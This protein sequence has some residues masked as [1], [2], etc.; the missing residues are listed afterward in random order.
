MKGTRITGLVFLGLMIITG[1]KK[2]EYIIAT[3]DDVLMGAYFERESERFSSFHEMLVKSGTL[4]FLNAYG[5]YTCFAPTNEAI[6]DF[7]V[8]RGKSSLDDFTTAE[9]VDLVRYHV[10]IDTLNSTR[11]T[12]GK[13]ST[14]NMYGQYLT[15]STYYESGQ[16]KVKINKYAEVE[17]LDIRVANGIIHSLK[18]VLEPIVVPIAGLV[19]ADPGLTIFT[20]ALKATGFYDTLSLVPD[21]QLERADKRWF[22]LFVHT[23]SVYSAEGINSFEDLKARYSDTGNPK[24][25]KD[26]LN[27]YVAYHILDNSLKYVADLVQENAHLTMAPLEVITIRLKQDSVLI[28]EDEFRGQIEKGA[29]V[30]R[31]KSDNTAANGVFHYVDANFAIKVRLPYA[32]YWDVCDQPEIRKLPGVF[33]VPGASAYLELGQLAGITWSTDVPIQYVCEAGGVQGQYLVHSDMMII[34]L[35]TASINWIEFKTPLIVKGKY[36]LWICTR[37]VDDPNRRPIFLVYFNGEAL[38]NIVA[39][40][41]TMERVSDEELLFQGFK[42]YNYD[43]ADSTGYLTDIN[44][45]FASRLAGTI[46]VPTTGNHTIKFQVINNG[47]KY[48]WIDMIHIIPFEN[49]QIWP[50]VGHDGTLMDKPDWY[51]LPQE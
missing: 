15:A 2:E 33:R 10:I 30:N 28:N 16:A 51:P 9:L 29:P 22:T 8:S 42:R 38:P 7:L 20:E 35:R 46:D 11:F 13:L 36:K 5:T 44:G 31:A 27:L 43:I 3:T 18:T 34:N 26:S 6:S 12:D 25:P 32:I 19:E 4:S 45:R 1:C 49:N 40:D 37:N 39:T 21:E 41:K 48:L 14:P 17:A 24:D 47:D 50:R 23:D